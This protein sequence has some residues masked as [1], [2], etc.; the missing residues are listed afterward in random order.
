ML[1]TREGPGGDRRP[2][3]EETPCHVV[4]QGV[5]FSYGKKENSVEDISFQLR[6]GE[7]LG[8]IGAT[9]CGKSTLMALLMRLYDATG[10]RS[11]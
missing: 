1:S 7:T 11:S 4:F 9:G 5:S 10:E 6:K 8:I 2:P 3:R